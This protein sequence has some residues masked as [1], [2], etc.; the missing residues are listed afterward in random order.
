[1]IEDN[2]IIE[3]IENAESAEQQPLFDENKKY[4]NLPKIVIAG[5]P[6]V[7]KSTLFN[8]LLHERRA[9]TDPTPGVTRDPIEEDC[10]ICGYPVRI[11]DT[12]GFKLEREIGTMEAMLDELVV[13]KT[14]ASLKD[15]DLILLL[16]EAGTITAEDEEFIA[17]LRPYWSKVVAAVNK[18]EG[19]RREEEAYNFYQ[20]GFDEL[21]FISAEHGDRIDELSEMLVKKLDFS[22]VEEGEEEEKIRIA[23]VGKPNTGKST[24]ANRLTHSEAS[25]V[26]DYAGTTRDVVE[27]DFEYKGN[28]FHII[29][30]AGIRRKAKV[31]EDVEYYSVN[32]AIKSL[33]DADIVFHMI[34]AQEGLAEQDKKIVSLA[35]ERGLGVIFVLNKWDT[36]EQSRKTFRNAEQNMKIMF[37][38]MSYAPVVALSA[39]EGKGIKDLLNTALEV[40]G[41][42]THKM[43]TGPLNTALKDWVSVYPPPAS[44]SGQFKVRYIVQTSVK[45]VNFLLFCTRPE[46]VS[47]SY[48]TFLKNRIRN[49]LGYDKIPVQLELKASRKKWEN[50]KK[51]RD[52]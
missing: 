2:E 40:Y 12:G 14:L 44:R 21:I 46:V 4:K 31:H 18:T 17:L 15:A 32:R 45:P 39:L 37:G 35:C 9:I 8:R 42:L 26:S 41:Q 47:Q 33:D 25:I 28:K 19:G 27:G 23:I 49:D 7:G 24:L 10:F 5:R 38:Q 16:L 48:L 13:E 20:Y 50:Y 34:D 52:S 51:D 30:T 36:Q 11:M 3:N 29:D 6:N 1:M 43:E 22:K